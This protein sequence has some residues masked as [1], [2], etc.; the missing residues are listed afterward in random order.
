MVL[1]PAGDFVSGSDDLY[2]A[3]DEG[4]PHTEYLPAFYI[5]RYEVT[6]IAYHEYDPDHTFPE[7][8][9]DYPVTG[10]TREQ[11]RAYAAAV[12]KRLPTAD[13]WEKAARGTDG[14]IYPWGDVFSADKANAGGGEGLMPVGSFPEGIS[15]YGAYDMVG[16]AWEWVDTTYADWSLLGGTDYTT[17]I[18]KGGGFSYSAYQCRPSY[19]GFEGNGGTCNDVGFRCAM[20][21]TPAS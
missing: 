4:A 3:P 10:L 5:D 12:G 14:R 16:N 11:A 17:E 7:G 6:N 13:E 21:P 15:P 19:N 9:D 20:D 1:V 2:A 8:H 18:I